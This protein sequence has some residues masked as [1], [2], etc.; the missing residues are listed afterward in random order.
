M[1]E[2]R[3]RASVMESQL[4]DFLPCDY[5]EV[6]GNGEEKSGETDDEETARAFGFDYAE[7]HKPSGN[8]RSNRLAQD[9]P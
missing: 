8:G 1:G 3:D 4:Y 7:F 6:N 5:K 2:R 9:Y